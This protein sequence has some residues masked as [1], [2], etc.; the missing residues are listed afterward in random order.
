M[1]L[2]FVTAWILS[3]PGTVLGAGGMW[4]A[5]MAGNRVVAERSS[6]SF[7]DGCSQLGRSLDHARPMVVVATDDHGLFGTTL[8]DSLVAYELK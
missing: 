5:A 7:P 3:L 6:D 4:L 8:G 1:V 2:T